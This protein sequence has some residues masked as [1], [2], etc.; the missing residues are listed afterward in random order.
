MATTDD[1]NFHSELLLQKS[2]PPIANSPYVANLPFYLIASM[3]LASHWW[4]GATSRELDTH[5]GN[6]KL[7]VRRTQAAA[8]DRKCAS[9]R[10]NVT[11]GQTIV[12]Q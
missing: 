3:M 1:Q 12:K 10:D 5:E 6:Y 4:S 2:N 7:A 8:G 9:Q 11:K